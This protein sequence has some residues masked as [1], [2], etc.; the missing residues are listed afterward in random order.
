[1]ID[2]LNKRIVIDA[3]DGVWTSDSTNLFVFRE[4]AIPVPIFAMGATVFESDTNGNLYIGSF[5]GLYKIDQKALLL[6][7][8]INGGNNLPTNISR[9]SENLVTGYFKDEYDNEYI[10][11]HYLG[12]QQISG[13]SNKIRYTMPQTSID[14]YKL[15]LWN[16]LFEIH[17]ARIFADWIGN[18][19]IL[20]IPLSSLM[21]LLIIISG[22]WDWIYK[23]I[24]KK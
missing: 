13:S 4:A 3:K 9:P 8:M 17:N 5:A 2:K 15:S 22:T 23:R 18:F 21:F 12:L 1:M 19:Y 20:V 14:N 24:I 7:D 6:F 16:Y 11:T 10:S